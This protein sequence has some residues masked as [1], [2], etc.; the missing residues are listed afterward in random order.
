MKDGKTILAIIPARG[1]SKGVPRKNIRVVAGKPLLAWTIEEAK[2]SEYIDRLVLSSEDK[3]II[4]IAEQWGCEAPFIRP[5]DLATDDA[6]GILTVLDAIERLPGYDVVVLLQPTSPLRTAEDI[7]GCIRHCL[8]NG[9]PACVS[10]CETEKSPFWI[11]KLEGP[12]F[13]HP[14]VKD[15]INLD[16]P[17]QKIPKT[18]VLNGAVYVAQASW[19]RENKSFLTEQS[20]GYIMPC[21][22]SLDID[23]EEDMKYFAFLKEWSHGKRG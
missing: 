2:K 21:E 7:D 22:R 19:L 17:R 10:L 23:T 14:V 3:E 4:R 12:G 1:G 6:A 13:M 20:L 15:A 11:F 8:D 9:S 5:A 18:Y 16:L